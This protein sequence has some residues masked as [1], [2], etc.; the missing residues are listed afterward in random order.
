[1]AH[2]HIWAQVGLGAFEFLGEADGDDFEEACWNL[3]SANREFRAEF[4]GK[5]M[6]FNGNSLV[7]LDRRIDGAKVQFGGVAS[8]RSESAPELPGRPAPKK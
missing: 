1:M 6:T 2:W 5:S 3:A 4:D 7:P 8:H